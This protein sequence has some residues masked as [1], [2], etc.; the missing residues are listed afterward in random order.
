[1]CPTSLL[2]HRK[3]VANTFLVN[4]IVCC[5]SITLHHADIVAKFESNPDIV[6]VPYP[7]SDAYSGV[8]P[9]SS[10]A[11]ANTFADL[12]KQFN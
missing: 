10:D 5:S 4:H 3:W 8:P 11:T 9:H 6:V 1:M 2:F 12:T 7:W